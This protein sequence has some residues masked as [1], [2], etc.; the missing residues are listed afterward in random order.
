[1]DFGFGKY[2]LHFDNNFCNYDVI[3]ILF[4]IQYGL[5]NIQISFICT[6]SMI[7]DNHFV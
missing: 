5:L 7:L 4:A 1:M 3:L 6:F 2:I